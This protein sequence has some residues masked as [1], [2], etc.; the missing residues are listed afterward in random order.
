MSFAATDLVVVTFVTREGSDAL[1]RRG[2]SD[3]S[4][5]FRLH[6]LFIEAKTGQVTAKRQWPTASD[7][8]GIIPTTGDNFLVVTPDRVMLYSPNLDLVRELDVSLSRDAALDNWGV[9]TSHPS[10]KYLFIGYGLTGSGLHGGGS[11]DENLGRKLVDVRNLEV[12]RVWTERGR[13]ASHYLSMADDGTWLVGQKIGKIGGP[14]DWLCLPCKPCGNLMFLNNQTLFSWDLY[15]KWIALR[16]SKGNLLLEQHFLRGEVFRDVVHS[17]DGCRFAIALDK[18]KGG[19]TV[20]DIGPHYSLNRIIVYDLAARQ[21][22][23]TLDAK[24]LGMKHVSGLALSPDGSLLALIN[25]DG[26][27]EAYHLPDGPF[28]PQ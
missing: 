13:S 27:L 14:L 10:G 3:T 18:G 20:L 5:P 19:S 15:L 24:K 17:A 28:K 11:A 9:Q 22:I 25:E 8:S 2:Q 1:P 26:I 6:A 16:G 21:W 12:L 7:R 23:Y 4:L